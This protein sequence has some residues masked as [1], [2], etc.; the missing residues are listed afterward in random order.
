MGTFHHLRGRT[1]VQPLFPGNRYSCSFHQVLGQRRNQTVQTVGSTP[2]LCESGEPRF[3]TASAKAARFREF[4]ADFREEFGWQLN[5][6]AP[7]IGRRGIRRAGARVGLPAG[8]AFCNVGNWRF[9]HQPRRKRASASMNSDTANTAP[10][11]S[12]RRVGM[13]AERKLN[14]VAA[15]ASRISIPAVIRQSC[16]TKL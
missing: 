9:V 7:A 10:C 14:R 8:G 13:S 16:S 2:V 11:P 15:V 4:S 12:Q 6:T 3:Q 5:C 1:E